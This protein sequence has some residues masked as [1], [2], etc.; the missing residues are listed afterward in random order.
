MHACGHG[1]WQLAR[2][3]SHA[4]MWQACA[5]LLTLCRMRKSTACAGVQQDPAPGHLLVAHGLRRG[6]LGAGGRRAQGLP[7][8]LLDGALLDQRRPLPGQV[9]TSSPA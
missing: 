8:R 4:H 7:S 3:S 5:M 1:W 6:H 9:Q 2:R